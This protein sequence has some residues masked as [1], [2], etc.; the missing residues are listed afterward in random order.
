LYKGQSGDEFSDECLPRNTLIGGDLEKEM[1]SMNILAGLLQPSKIK[2]AFLDYIKRYAPG[3][4]R[5]EMD[6]ED[7]YSLGAR[8]YSWHYEK[9]KPSIVIEHYRDI[10]IARKLLLNVRF[11]GF[12]LRSLIVNQTQ[13]DCDDVDR[14]M[15]YLYYNTGDIGGGNCEHLEFRKELL[16][17]S[18]QINN[19]S[20]IL[21]A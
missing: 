20:P 17:R 14:R 19:P 16:R 13:R 21:E 8:S 15:Y 2:K 11:I 5:E 7:W 1:I 12:Y 6:S 10:V 9:N 3:Y 18:R 4:I